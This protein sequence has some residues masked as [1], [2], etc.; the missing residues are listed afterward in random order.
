MSLQY[1]D[2]KLFVGFMTYKGRRAP[3]YPVCYDKCGADNNAFYNAIQK[4]VVFVVLLMYQRIEFV[5]TVGFET[6]K[7]YFLLR[8]FLL[9]SLSSENK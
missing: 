8:R 9:L 1:S 3:I 5:R 7:D 6:A 2:E 4:W